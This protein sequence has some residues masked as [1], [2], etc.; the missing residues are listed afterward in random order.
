MSYGAHIE[1]I[2][3]ELK[4]SGGM[5]SDEEDQDEGSDSEE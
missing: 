2:I 3:G 1:S 5:G 4:E